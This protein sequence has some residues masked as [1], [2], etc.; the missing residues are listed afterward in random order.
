[1]TLSD[2]SGFVHDPHGLDAERLAVARELKEVR[3][4]RISDYVTRFPDATYHPGARPWAV[5][6]D[7]A[8]PCATQDELGLDD[9]RALIGHG[10]LGVFEGANLPTTPDAVGALRAAGRLFVPGKAA[11]A[12]GVAVSGLEMSQNAQRLTWTRD[13]V[14]A[15]LRAIMADIHARCLAEGEGPGGVVDYRRGADVAGYR[16]VAAARLALGLG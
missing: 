13:E 12:G 11:N 10:C 9:A 8:F 15:R 6:C 2:S 16:R 1:M 14:D 7:L 3:R 5:P 4:A